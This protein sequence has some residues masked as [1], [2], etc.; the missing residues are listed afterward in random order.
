MAINK[1][2]IHF[3]TLA[4]FNAQLSAGNI[5]DTSIVFIKDAKKIWTHG[6][7][8]DCSGGS[9]DN[10]TES[11]AEP[12][13]LPMTVYD[14]MAGRGLDSV[15]ITELLDAADN[16]N[17]ILMLNDSEGN[18]YVRATGC[19]VD[20]DYI[21]V[22]FH[23]SQMNTYND[24]GIDLN[25]YISFD[26]ETGGVDEWIE[27][28]I[29][30]ITD[31]KT[32]NGQSLLGSGN[33]TIEGGSGG[34]YLPLTG[35]TLTGPVV[36]KNGGSISVDSN[37]YLNLSIS[38]YLTLDNDVKSTYGSI[39]LDEGTFKYANGEGGYTQ[40]TGMAYKKVS[41]LNG[42]TVTLLDDIF[43]DFT[44]MISGNVIFAFGTKRGSG[45]YMFRFYVQSGYSVTLPNTLYFLG[46]EPTEEQC[47]YEVS[48][49]NSVT[50]CVKIG[51]KN[52]YGGQ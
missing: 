45:H 3:Q 23:I 19:N 38:E 36:F 31:I 24:R 13:V 29:S 20:D 44:T 32:I 9:G 34:D 11:G 25:I 37:D 5:L 40:A 30:E 50:I 43:Y 49:Y 7:L 15:N 46:D 12:F 51:T 39:T 41:D 35:G 26:R 1:K 8:Y 22:F 18:G 28:P 27:T 17:P 33:I 4:N 47:V 48:V 2:L 10:T 52:I 21:F 6:Q 14:L 42:G 16:G